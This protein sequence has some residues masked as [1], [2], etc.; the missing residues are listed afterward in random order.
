MYECQDPISVFNL[1]NDAIIIHNMEDGSI[2]DANVVTTALL[3]YTVDEL[4]KLSVDDFSAGTKEFNGEVALGW[5]R[6]AAIT[7]PVT[8]EWYFKRKDGRLFW[9]EV[10]LKKAM[11]EGRERVIA[12]I[13]DITERKHLSD[14]LRSE[15]EIFFTLLNELPAFVCLQDSNRNVRFSNKYVKEHFGDP[16]GKKCHEILAGNRNP[17]EECPMDRVI[18]SK[19]LIRRERQL[20]DGKKYQVYNYYFPDTDGTPL[21]LHIGFDITELDDERERAELY[22]DLISHDINNLNQVAMGY[23][24]LGLEAIK[25]GTECTEYIAKPLEMLRRSSKLIDNVKK[26]QRAS[27]SRLSLKPVDACATVMEIAG[28]YAVIM[29][30]KVDIRIEGDM[31]CPVMANELIKDVFANLIDNA[32]KHSRRDD[33]NIVIRIKAGKKGGDK[34]FISIEDN[35]PGIDD[36]VKPLIFQRAYRSET[37]SGYGLGLYLVKTLVESYNGTIAIEDSVA[38]DHSK[39]AR[40]VLTLPAA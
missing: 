4:K 32:V 28:E 7:G 8:V 10:S 36:S 33:V 9:G 1:V 12:I 27:A 22:L 15:R 13:R 2:V 40:F 24:E 31:S 6:K 26:I 17:C 18:S 37:S 34:C 5:I 39:G 21:M 38:G 11:F 14:D 20:I 29:G 30:K 35:G 3:G 16:T 25:S 19:E 23:L